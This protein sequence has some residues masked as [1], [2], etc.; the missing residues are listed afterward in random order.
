MK[1]PDKLLTCGAETAIVLGSGLAGFVQSLPEGASI[2][3]SS[4][5]GLPCSGVPGHAGRFLATELGGRKLLIAQGRVHLYEGW[6]A[7]E[8]ARGIE[9]MHSIGIK[10]LLL[11]N[12]AGTLNNHH[13][14]GTWM[15]LTDHINLL[16]DSP[17]RGGP[18][19]FDMSEVY[20]LRLRGIFR[21]A[22]IAEK[23]L[24]HEG[25]Y[26]AMPGPQFETPAE[27]RMLQAIGADAVGMSTVPEAIQARAMGMEVAGLSCLTNWA[28]GLSPSPL[29][30]EEVMT[31]GREAAGQLLTLV[32]RVLEKI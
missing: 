11:T 31:T 8:V 13:A 21:E 9:L 28:A 2:D 23:I 16:G 32:G 25:V 7:R 12:A 19:F 24:L 18:H 22:A 17:L 30:H 15:M 27:I 10:N 14:P 26:A 6:S 20:S 4:I 1:I 5:E 3:Y 29:T